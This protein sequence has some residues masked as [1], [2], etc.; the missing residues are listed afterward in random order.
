MIVFQKRK[1]RR[2]KFF[3]VLDQY[4]YGLAFQEIEIISSLNY[5]N[6]AGHVDFF[7]F[8]SLQFAWLSLCL[9]LS[10]TKSD[11]T[12]VQRELVPFTK[13]G[14][15]CAHLQP[16]QLMLGLHL[17]AHPARRVFLRPVRT[18]LDVFFCKTEIDLCT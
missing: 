16:L 12:A 9:S 18:Q 14:R 17:P 4:L 6:Q 3:R 5:Y 13:T 8:K 11:V 10:Q 15:V 1:Y 7:A 2:L